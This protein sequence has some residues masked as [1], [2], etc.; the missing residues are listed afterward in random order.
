ML[1]RRERPHTEMSQQAAAGP[2][3]DRGNR[4]P[5]HFPQGGGEL[6]KV[7]KSPISE[8]AG[9]SFNKGQKNC[10]PIYA[11]AQK[12]CELLPTYVVG[13]GIPGCQD[14]ADR[15]ETDY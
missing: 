11:V 4:K 10:C 12:H 9:D 13:G 7:F 14:S 3:V 1:P 6:I 5:R 2:G 8:I 15:E